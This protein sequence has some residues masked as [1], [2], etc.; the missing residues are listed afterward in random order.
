MK[1]KR[2]RNGCLH[3]TV[4]NDVL[5][6]TRYGT[7]C[8]DKDMCRL[9]TDRSAALT[10]RTT[11]GKLSYMSHRRTFPPTHRAEISDRKRDPSSPLQS[12]TRPQQSPCHFWFGCGRWHQGTLHQRQNLTFWPTKHSRRSRQ[13]QLHIPAEKRCTE[14]AVTAQRRD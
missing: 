14:D 5:Q 13:I 3:V 1:H 7:Q 9:G 6:T 12:S 11:N 4:D 2:L 8:R 10:F